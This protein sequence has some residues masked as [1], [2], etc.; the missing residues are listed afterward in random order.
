MITVRTQ[1]KEIV[2]ECEGIN[3][4][5]EDFVEKLDEKVNKLVEEACKRA[6]EN[7]RRTVMGKDV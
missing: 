1:I 7:G 3:N 4:I 6:K 5:S 2:N